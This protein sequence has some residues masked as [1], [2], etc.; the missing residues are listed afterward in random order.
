MCTSALLREYI[1]IFPSSGDRG[2]APIDY[3][4]VDPAWYM[5]RYKTFIKYYLMCDFMINT[6]HRTVKNS[7][8]I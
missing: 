8:I 2:F 5:E 6:F 7:K 3:F 1:T 4:K